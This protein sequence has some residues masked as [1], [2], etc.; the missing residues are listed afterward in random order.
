MANRGGGGNN[1]NL[2]T[3]ASFEAAEAARRNQIQRELF[4]LVENTP[5][6]M[7]AILGAGGFRLPRT[8]EQA[9]DGS[10]SN[11]SEI[12]GSIDFTTANRIDGLSSLLRQTQRST[13]ATSQLAALNAASQAQ[14]DD[15]IANIVN[16][17]VVSL[18]NNRNTPST[19]GDRV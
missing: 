1:A 15:D 8:L 12:L 5:S 18:M 6:A 7:E 10:F 2:N 19:Q 13:A 11:L 17:L 9:R 4:S 16:S 3:L 14:Q